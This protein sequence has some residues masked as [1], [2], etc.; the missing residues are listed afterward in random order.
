MMPR[1]ILGTMLIMVVNNDY[2][3]D[4]VGD[5]DVGDNF[6]NDDNDD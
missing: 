2:V 3:H 5:D 4:D 6:V 1:T